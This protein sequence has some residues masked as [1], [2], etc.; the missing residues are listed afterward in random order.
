MNNNFKR[1]NI[2]IFQNDIGVQTY[3]FY[4][5]S[6]FGAC[7]KALHMFYK[8]NPEIKDKITAKAIHS[9]FYGNELPEDRI[10]YNY[11]IPYVTAH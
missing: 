6:N 8:D 2:V 5:S 10:H 11:S 4:S 9:D 3:T 7:K 1:Y